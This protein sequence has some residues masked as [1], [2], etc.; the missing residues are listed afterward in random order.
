MTK[1]KVFVLFWLILPVALGWVISFFIP[2]YSY[3]RFLFA[4]PALYIL[5]ACGILLFRSAKARIILASVVLLIGLTSQ[6]IFWVN[7]RFHREDWRSAVS[8][9]EAQSRNQ[10]VACV[11]VNLAQTAPFKY[12][13]KN[14]QI[15][16]PHDWQDKNLNTIWLSRYVQ[17]IFDSSDN[18]RKEIEN[19]GF[20]KVEE[21]D[22]NG[23]VFWRYQKVYANLY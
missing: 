20:V 9:I 16:G 2:V 11:F 14:V 17:P 8:Y 6:F 23:V 12:Y 5:L 21:K 10:N 13:S 1:E 15:L 3:F 4:L 18:L 22:F 19:Q 7:P